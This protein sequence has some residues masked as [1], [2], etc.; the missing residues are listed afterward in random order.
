MPFKMLKE[1]FGPSAK[2]IRDRK[3]AL[4]ESRDENENPE[5]FWKPHPELPTDKETYVEEVLQILFSS[6]MPVDR[7]RSVT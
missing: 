7:S 6:T 1:K 3:Y 2:A 5:P 4:E